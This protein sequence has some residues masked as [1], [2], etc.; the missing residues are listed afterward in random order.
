MLRALAKLGDGRRCVILG[1]SAE[2]I[3]RLQAG[4][5]IFLELEDILVDTPICIFTGDTEE[6][7]AADLHDY[8]DAANKN[9]HWSDEPPDWAK[10]RGGKH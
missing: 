10:G 5:P 9:V 3:K 7:M 8:M 1:L 2:N 4:E 6:Q